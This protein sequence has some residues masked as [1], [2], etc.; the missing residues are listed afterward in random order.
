[1]TSWAEGE[2]SQWR[3]VDMDGR[4]HTILATLVLEEVGLQ[5]L[6]NLPID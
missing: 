4:P 2:I 3:E 6:D 5:I 1:M